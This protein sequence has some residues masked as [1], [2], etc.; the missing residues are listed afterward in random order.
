MK[1]RFGNLLCI[2]QIT[3]YETLSKQ[4]SLLLLYNA[5]QI[6]LLENEIKSGVF[7]SS[8]MIFIRENWYEIK[9]SGPS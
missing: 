5:R 7:S 8:V 6:G 2:L 4:D 9:K 3:N 1:V